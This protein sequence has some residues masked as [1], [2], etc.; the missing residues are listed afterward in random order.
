MPRRL[1]AKVER[2]SANKREGEEI[3]LATGSF[4][5]LATRLE[6]CSPGARCRVVAAT[7]ELALKREWGSRDTEVKRSPAV[8]N[9]GETTKRGRSLPFGAHFKEVGGSL[10]P[11]NVVRDLKATE[12]RRPLH[13]GARGGTEDGGLVFNYGTTFTAGFIK[14]K[15]RLAKLGGTL[16]RLRPKRY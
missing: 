3:Y 1:P 8:V 15:K 13:R 10:G 12:R 14:H 16:Q 9:S 5:I 4:R 11:H 6:R 2:K 7:R